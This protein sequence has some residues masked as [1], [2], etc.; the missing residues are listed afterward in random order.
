MSKV[1]PLS[2][3]RRGRTDAPAARSGLSSARGES[4]TR[5]AEAPLGRWHA[6]IFEA[7]RVEVPSAKAASGNGLLFWKT[8][9]VT[10]LFLVSVAVFLL[11]LQATG[12]WDWM[13]PLTRR[14]LE[15]PVLAPHVEM[16]RLGRE[17]WGD[18]QS[19]R[20][21]LAEWEK[22]LSVEE[23]RLAELERALQRSQN[24]L[25]LQRQQLAAWEA[26]L[27]ARQAALE[28][29]EDER[30]AV[31]RVRE[32]YEAMRPQDAARILA[33]MA[34]EEVAALLIDMDPRTAANILA[35]LPVQKAAVVSRLL[36]L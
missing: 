26:E 14:L 4:T 10:V 2:A 34:D 27:T 33:D 16:Y 35:A 22:R 30:Q 1:N 36:G 23:A 19:E 18:L 9:G 24:Q 21:R 13:N 5:A 17:A 25:E 28:R 20:A 15:W 32:M 12:L 29:L 8:L 11:V 3:G 6:P 7:T 31:Q